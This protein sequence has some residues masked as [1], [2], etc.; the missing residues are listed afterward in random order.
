MF[1]QALLELLDQVED[2]IAVDTV[3]SSIALE[4][5]SSEL[6]GRNGN[7]LTTR[8]DSAAMEVPKKITQAVMKACPSDF[9]VL[10]VYFTFSNRVHYQDC[11]SFSSL[12]I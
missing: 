11:T 9:L 4:D 3:A 5:D 6:Q 2:V 1:L 10:E 12:M 7:K 8:V